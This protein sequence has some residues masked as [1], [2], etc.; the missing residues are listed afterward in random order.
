[1]SD[2]AKSSF[3][4]CTLVFAYGPKPA[5]GVLLSRY[6]EVGVFAAADT[7]RYELHGPTQA[8]LGTSVCANYWL[9]MTEGSSVLKALVDA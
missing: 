9:L 1:M 8:V 2:P 6:L 3:S 4:S 7:V 5:A